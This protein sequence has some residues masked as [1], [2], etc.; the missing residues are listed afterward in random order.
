ME[1]FI[2]KYGTITED[3][4]GKKP[5]WT[6]FSPLDNISVASSTK[7]APPK[8]GIQTGMGENVGKSRRCNHQAESLLLQG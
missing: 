3:G 4:K 2:N 1:P 6:G 5:E 7:D 8:L